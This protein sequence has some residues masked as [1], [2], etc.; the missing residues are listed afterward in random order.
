MEI[1]KLR[2]AAVAAVASCL[3]LGGATASLALGEDAKIASAAID[4]SD[5]KTYGNVRIW[6]RSNGGNSIGISNAQIKL[7]FHS[8]SGTSDNDKG[9]D[10]HVTGIIN[11]NYFSNV[12]ENHTPYYYAD[13]PYDDVIGS[14]LTVQRFDPMNGSL[15]NNI[16][17]VQITDANLTALFDVDGSYSL[18]AEKSVAWCDYDLAAFALGGLKTCSASPVNGYMAFKNI[19]DTF[20]FEAETANSYEVGKD[21]GGL[22][23]V[24]GSL[25][26]KIISDYEDGADWK[27]SEE[28]LATI[29]GY[30]KYLALKAL[31]DAHNAG[32]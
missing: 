5:T 6:I 3:A 12:S 27:K 14:Y 26:D 29:D 10:T 24:N 22:W 20:I 25:G 32:I 1:K 9:R 23:Q 31:Y 8:G 7:W 28:K 21:M 30:S 11:N 19:V 13:V 15:W 17:S 2:I 18:S 4:T 16:G